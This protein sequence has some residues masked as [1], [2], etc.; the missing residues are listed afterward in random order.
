MINCHSS[1]ALFASC[2]QDAFPLNLWESSLTRLSITG[3]LAALPKH[4]GWIK[5]IDDV[6]MCIW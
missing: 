3:E 1:R 5:F 6:K 2:I 4:C